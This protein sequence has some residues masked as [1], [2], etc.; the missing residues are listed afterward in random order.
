MA[1]PTLRPTSEQPRA[2]LVQGSGPGLSGEVHGLLKR[3]L[4]GATL[5]LFFGFGLFLIRRYF[6]S[7]SIEAPWWMDVFHVAVVA[8]LGACGFLLYVRC[9][10][11]LL[12][13]RWAELVVFGLPG[14]FFLA[15]QY[16]VVEMSARDQNAVGVIWAVLSS[17]V[18]WYA[19]IF[20]Y[21]MFIPNS[22]TRATAIMIPMAVA[23]VVL[24]LLQRNWHETVA[25]A[26]TFDTM[27]QIILMMVIAAFCAIYGSHKIHVL[28]REAFEAKELGQYRLKRLLGSGGMGEVFLAEHYLL[29]RPCAIKV[30]RPGKAAD[31]K[32]LARFEREVQA[33]ARLSHWNTVEI[34]DYGRTD[35]GT[36][37][38]VM[39]YLPGM[40]LAELVDGHGPLPPERVVHLLL[41][42][43]D[44]LGEAHAHGLIHRDIKPGNIFAA[45]RG[46]IYDVAKL[47]DFGLV[48]PIDPE[49]PDAL[50]LTQDGSITGSPLY[51][52]PEQA[53]GNTEP[54]ARSDIYSLGAVSYF[55]LTGRPPFVGE[56]AIQV[57]F[58]HAH[59][60]VVPPSQLVDGVPDDLERIVLR[61]LEKKPHDRFADI[62]SLSSALAATDAA[63][64]WSQQQAAAWWRDADLEVESQPA[65]VWGRPKQG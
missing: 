33:T 23:P 19:L 64:K 61:C 55:L 17:V 45:Q 48:K 29:K 2:A 63:E 10:T 56:K 27:V 8:V 53:L 1:A 37:Y 25:A 46:G 32:I 57:M 47:L 26:V 38:Y 62:R 34:F 36:F 3:R 59:D 49:D 43:C 41:Q 21:A 13:L 20:T 14:A 16:E 31:P 15:L 58:A 44:A 22:L 7:E 52:S 60:P 39:E 24:T 40:S 50:E 9:P 6:F 42:T 18:F 11:S 51:M 54:D 5:V 4:R 12:R 65:A 28:R 30:I 35:D